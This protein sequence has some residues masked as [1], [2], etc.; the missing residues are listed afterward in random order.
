M[1]LH[2]KDGR[3]GALLVLL[4]ALILSACDGDTPAAPT[5]TPVVD[6]TNPG[7]VSGGASNPG[8]SAPGNPSPTGRSLVLYTTR[9]EA[10]IKPVI[11]AFQKANPDIQVQLLTGN[12]GTLGAKLIE[13]R[14]RTQADVYLST[15]VLN[16][17]SLAQ[18]GLFTPVAADTAVKVPAQ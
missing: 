13:E 5:S 18:Q 9:S 12:A 6:S 2:M 10:L 8:E 7:N 3:V 4:M 15:D 11:D 17:A 1:K 14:G 16:I